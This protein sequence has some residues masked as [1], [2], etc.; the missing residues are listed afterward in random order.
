MVGRS[1]QVVEMVGRGSLDFCCLQETRWKGDGARV[2]EAAGKKY[3]IFW[4]DGE[5]KSLGVGI[6]VA[7]EVD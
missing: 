6:L 3:K 1:G 2:I 7:Q 5:E 4:K